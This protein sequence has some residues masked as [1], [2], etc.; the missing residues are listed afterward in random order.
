MTWKQKE[1]HTVRRLGIAGVVCVIAAALGLTLAPGASA[2]GVTK[3][4]AGTCRSGVGECTYGSDSSRFFTQAAGHPEEGLTDFEFATSSF[5][6][7][8]LGLPEGAVKNVRVDLPEGL[9]VDPQAVPQCPKATFEANPAQCEA[10]G[11][12]VGISEVTAVSLGGLVPIG[13]TGPLSPA[14]YN[15]EPDPGHPAL[16]GFNVNVAGVAD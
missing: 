3:W 15:L 6:G 9:N 13:L 16:F 12:K 10:M 8:P 5:L 1:N 14:V 2:F 7:L 11:S 4:E